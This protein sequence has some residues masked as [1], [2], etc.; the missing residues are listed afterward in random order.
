MELTLSDEVL[1]ACDMVHD[2]ILYPMG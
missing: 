1:K 2:E